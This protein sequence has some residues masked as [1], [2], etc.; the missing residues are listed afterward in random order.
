MTRHLNGLRRRHGYHQRHR[1]LGSSV[2]AFPIVALVLT[3]LLLFAVQLGYALSLKSKLD[4]VAY[5]LA[6]VVT[7]EQLE[8]PLAGAHGEITAA[9]SSDLQQVAQR[10]FATNESAGPQIS[11]LLEQIKFD[12]R[13]DVLLYR[14]QH[15]GL[16]CQAQQALPKL[17]M[18]SPEGGVTGANLG[19]KAD[20]FQVSVC[21]SAIPILVSDIFP[22]LK[23][24]G[25]DYFTSSAVMIG[26]QYAP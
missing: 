18:L 24:L 9:M 20:L 12:D 10:Y 2:I 21:L 7:S 14:E 11:L 13:G 23:G 6:S 3:L 17:S 1:Q 15:E 8:V 4:R 26:R 19:E 22:G 16:A 25:Q 5:A